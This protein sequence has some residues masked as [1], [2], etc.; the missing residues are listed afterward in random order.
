[1][2]RQSRPERASMMKPIRIQKGLAKVGIYH[3]I[4]RDE[5]LHFQVIWREAGKLHRKQFP[6][7]PE[8]KEYA[9]EQ[10]TRLA[11]GGGLL[12]PVPRK[13]IAKYR[14]LENMLGGQS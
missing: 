2:P 10:A 11:D 1:M 4:N 6:T 12:V 14:S 13:E 7:L 9:E 3:V 5:W 8:A